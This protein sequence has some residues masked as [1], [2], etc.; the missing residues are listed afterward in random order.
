[1]STT[2]NLPLT[3]TFSTADGIT[4]PSTPATAGATVLS[5]AADHRTLLGLGTAATADSADFYPTAEPIGVDDLAPLVPAYTV[6]PLHTFPV[7]RRAEPIA[8][9]IRQNTG[10]R[11]QWDVI[12]DT[13]HYSVGVDQIA[14]TAST[15]NITVTFPDAGAI[16][17]FQCVPDE[18]LAKRFGMAVGASVTSEA[19]IQGSALVW[20]DAKIYYDGAD[21]IV[22]HTATSAN[23]EM[24]FTTRWLAG[25]LYVDS[26][27]ATVS[28]F[29][30]GTIRPPADINLIPYFVTLHGTHTTASTGLRFHDGAA[31]VTTANTRMAVIFTKGLA[32][33]TV[34]LDGSSGS[35]RLQLDAGNI[36][37]T[38][39]RLP[40]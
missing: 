15:S 11:T 14:F 17:S 31:Y 4:F 5:T 13:G 10:D 27:Y 29:T 9:V 3:S 28:E 21:W 30:V 36:W 26:T 19:V 24:D 40:A 8:L 23:R 20:A 22:S 7:G 34:R 37:I 2:L 38:G 39:W 12:S 32:Q 6:N 35:E 16:I 1:M 25:V 33:R 18:S